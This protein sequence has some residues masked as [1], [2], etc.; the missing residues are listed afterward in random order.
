MKF[1]GNIFLTKGSM[2][3]IK[4]SGGISEGILPLINGAEVSPSIG[5]E[6][7]Y[8]IYTSRI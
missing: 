2:L 6:V 4:A 7:D 5:L 3:G 8:N 1:A